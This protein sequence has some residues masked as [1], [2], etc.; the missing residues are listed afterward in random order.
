MK[1]ILAAIFALVL[2]SCA[3]WVDEMSDKPPGERLYLRSC[4]KC[5][6]LYSPA[7]KSADEWRRAVEKYGSR[8]GLSAGEK[9]EI[10]N[11]LE[12]NCAK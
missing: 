4:G 10:L 7:E 1:M 8:L 2:Y 6:R 9:R 12:L 3:G 5:H 11:Y